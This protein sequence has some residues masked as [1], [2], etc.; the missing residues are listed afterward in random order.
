MS[1]EHRRP[2]WGQVVSSTRQSH[3]KPTEDSYTGRLMTCT[4]DIRP[5]H[6]APA[7][8]ARAV[9]CFD[10]SA[11]PRPEPPRQCPYTDISYLLPPF[12]TPYCV[13]SRRCWTRSGVCAVR[14]C[15]GYTRTCSSWCWAASSRCSSKSRYDPL[16]SLPYPLL[17][18]Y[19]FLASKG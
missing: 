12:S 19:P 16:T 13:S 15:S 17:Q 8:P 9:A 10:M 11:R 6:L 3:G 7:H 4:R 18:V 2:K 5:A 14:R 1:A